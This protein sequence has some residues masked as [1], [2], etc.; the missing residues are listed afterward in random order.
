MELAGVHDVDQSIS[1]CLEQGDD[2]SICLDMFRHWSW[3]D[4]S[5]SSIER[6]GLHRNA[7]SII[8]TLFVV[9]LKTTKYSKYAVLSPLGPLGLGVPVSD[10]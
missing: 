3:R 4:W 10:Y 6:Q 9:G 8:S 7:S 2:L 5:S 1:I